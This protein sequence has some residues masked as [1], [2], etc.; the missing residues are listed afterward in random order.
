MCAVRA[1]LLIGVG[2]LWPNCEQFET[3]LPLTGKKLD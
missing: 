2:Y 1:I 3:E